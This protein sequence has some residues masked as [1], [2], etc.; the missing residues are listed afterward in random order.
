MRRYPSGKQSLF[1]FVQELKMP[2][3]M[4]TSQQRKKDK[5]SR[6][7][8]LALTPSATVAVEASTNRQPR[9]IFLFARPNKKRTK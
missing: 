5:S 6:Q 3:E 2:E 8:K 9:S 4:I 7:P 1:N